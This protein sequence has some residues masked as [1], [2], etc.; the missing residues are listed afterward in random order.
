MILLSFHTI[1]VYILAILQYF[2]WNLAVHT[3]IVLSQSSQKVESEKFYGQYL[4]PFFL[5][6]SFVIALVPAI[7]LHILT[8][9]RQW[10]NKWPFRSSD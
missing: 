2:T 10:N 6:Y 1:Q 5:D 7:Y 9:F 4:I 8:A 3:T